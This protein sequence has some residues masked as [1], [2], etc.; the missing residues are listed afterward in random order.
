IVILNFFFLVLLVSF[1]IYGLKHWSH[2]I[3][4]P[5]EEEPASDRFDTF[6]YRLPFW[7]LIIG[8]GIYGLLN[9]FLDLFAG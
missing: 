7:I 6:Y 4:E 9:D 1:F 5:D 8:G 3:N 2:L